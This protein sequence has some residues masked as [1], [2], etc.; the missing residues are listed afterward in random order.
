MSCVSGMCDKEGLYVCGQNYSSLCV[1]EA[2]KKR[3]LPRSEDCN[4]RTA[5][6]MSH[7][8]AANK[9]SNIQGGTSIIPPWSVDACLWITDTLTNKIISANSLTLVTKSLSP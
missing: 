9:P 4:L 3:Q 8:A 6:V 2:E 1:G 5:E 7:Y